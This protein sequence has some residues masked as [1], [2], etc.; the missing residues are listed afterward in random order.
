MGGVGPE[1][2]GFALTEGLQKLF[3]FFKKPLKKIA[4][5]LAK[6]LIHYAN[7]R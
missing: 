7:V 4:R 1:A 2:Q 5:P 3:I 6:I